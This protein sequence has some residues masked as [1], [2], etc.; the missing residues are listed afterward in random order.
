MTMVETARELKVRM[1]TTMNIAKRKIGEEMFDAGSIEP[2]LF[3]LLIN[4][5]QMCTLYGKLVEE[6]AEIINE[7][8]NKL[9]RLVGE[10]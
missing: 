7:M 5:F 2:E 1:D 9:D 6:Q 4:M 10:N 3:E 8:N